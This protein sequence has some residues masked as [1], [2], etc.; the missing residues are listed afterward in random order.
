MRERKENHHKEIVHKSRT[1]YPMVVDKNL[2]ASFAESYRTTYTN[3]HYSLNGKSGKLLLVTSS[4]PQE[5]KTTTAANLALTIA[6]GGQKVLLVDTDLRIPSIHKIFKHDRNRG[7]TNILV[8]IYGT[9]LTEGDLLH[10]GLGDLLHIMNIQGKSGLLSISENGDLYHL[11][12]QDG[13]L[14]DVQ[15]KTRPQE[16]RIGALLVES[17]RITMDQKARALK[18]QTSSQER[19]GSI[20]V[21]MNLVSPQEMEGPLKLHISETLQRLS[22]LKSGT[23]CFQAR[24]LPEDHPISINGFDYPHLLESIQGMMASRETHTPFID[25]KVSSYLQDGPIDNL[26][27]LN[28]GPIPSNATELLGSRRMSEL[29]NVLKRKFNT[30]I[31]DSPP[32]NSVSDACILSSRVD[33]IILVVCAGRTNRRGVQRAKQ[34]LE[35]A[36]ARICGVILNR[37]DVRKGGYYYYSYYHYYYGHYHQPKAN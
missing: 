24:N 16:E 10:Y 8:D 21:S 14:V 29:I 7:L 27:V 32:L 36:G 13:N 17:G 26:R 12:F 19:L 4:L 33:G 9:D 22:S 5:G 28:S 20:L 30:I 25:Q 35:T 3:V 37:L 11:Q 34:Q 31:F 2:S 23:F 1:P 15:W 18:R 6:E